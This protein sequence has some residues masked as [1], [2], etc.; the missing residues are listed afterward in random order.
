MQRNFLPSWNF[1]FVILRPLLYLFLSKNSLAKCYT[2]YL[3]VTRVEQNHVLRLQFIEDATC[4][5]IQW[6]LR[7]SLTHSLVL[8]LNSSIKL[9]TEQ[10]AYVNSHSYDMTQHNKSEDKFSNKLH[11]SMG[12]ITV[13]NDVLFVNGTD[14]SIESCC[15]CII[16]LKQKP[17]QTQPIRFGQFIF[18]SKCFRIS[19]VLLSSPLLSSLRLSIWLLVLMLLSLFSTPMYVLPFYDICTHS[20]RIVYT[21]TQREKS[22]RCYYTLQFYLPSILIDTPAAHFTLI[23]KVDILWTFHQQICLVFVLML[24][25]LTF[26]FFV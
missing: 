13:I 23:H 14:F 18:I 21:Y 20:T 26:R 7:L 9:Y 24:L 1:G 3:K 5:I 4:D 15:C 22:P 16:S 17:Q 8:S 10:C 11:Y 12:I 19:I 2:H 25:L 6:T